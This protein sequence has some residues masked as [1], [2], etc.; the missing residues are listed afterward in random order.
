MAQ[1]L[2]TYTCNPIQLHLY[3]LIYLIL[4]FQ[5]YERSSMFTGLTLVFWMKTLKSTEK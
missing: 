2:F 5:N 3:N 4:G 1:L